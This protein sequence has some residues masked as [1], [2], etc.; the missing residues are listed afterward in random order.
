MKPC[1]A[2]RTGGENEWGKSVFIKIVGAGV[3]GVEW[4][5]IVQCRGDQRGNE[6]ARCAGLINPAEEF[7]CFCERAGKLLI[8]SRV[9]F[10]IFTCMC[11][12]WLLY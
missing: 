6:I 11:S 1:Q 8:Q 12:H 10:V 7:G 2:D 4:A 5:R 9:A 3:A